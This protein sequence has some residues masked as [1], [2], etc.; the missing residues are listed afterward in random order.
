MYDEKKE[1]ELYT[2]KENK[3]K[4]FILTPENKKQLLS[5]NEYCRTTYEELYKKVIDTIHV[6]KKLLVNNPEYSTCGIKGMLSFCFRDVDDDL[7]EKRKDV[8]DIAEEYPLEYMIDIPAIVSRNTASD[9]N[10]IVDI[11][12]EEEIFR[13]PSIDSYD[14][15]YQNGRFGFIKPNFV[16]NHIFD[17]LPI[18]IVDC[19]LFTGKFL[20]ASV[21]VQLIK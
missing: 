14:L 9:D 12:S 3:D 7:Y 2:Q 10:F 21:E 17:G 20:E 4:E 19:S 15:F 13:E 11:Q 6:C 5:I 18:S 8:F 1:S 16:F